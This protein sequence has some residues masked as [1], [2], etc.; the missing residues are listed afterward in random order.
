MNKVVALVAAMTAI[1]SGSAAA[2]SAA[3]DVKAR[4][5]YARVIWPRY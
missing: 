5:I 3:H 4:E 2:Q 1:L